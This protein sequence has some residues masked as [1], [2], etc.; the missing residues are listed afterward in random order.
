MN[1]ILGIEDILLPIVVYIAI[2]GGV[3]K[4]QRASGGTVTGVFSQSR[5]HLCLNASFT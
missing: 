1:P 4:A 5:Y 3:I 2:E